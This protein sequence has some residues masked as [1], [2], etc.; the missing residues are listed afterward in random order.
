MHQIVRHEPAAG[1]GSNHFNGFQVWKGGSNNCLE[2]RKQQVWKGGSN[3]D[4]LLVHQ[5]RD[6]A[7]TSMGFK[8]YSTSCSCTKLCA[9]NS[10]PS[11]QATTSMRFSGKGPSHVLSCSRFARKWAGLVHSPAREG[12]GRTAALTLRCGAGRKELQWVQ[13]LSQQKWLKPRPEYGLDWLI[14][15]KV[16]RQWIV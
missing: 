1:G 2:G 14:C 12:E 7:T 6:E 15:S 5:P 13:R 3:N 8:T 10:L 4:L 11:E 9:T 16:A